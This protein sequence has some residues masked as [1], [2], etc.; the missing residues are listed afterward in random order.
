MTIDAELQ[1][2]Y[3]DG[4]EEKSGGA[5]VTDPGSG[6][7]LVLTS[8]P[9]YDPTLMA[10]GISDEEYQAYVDNPESPFLARYSARYAPASTFKIITAAIG[11]DTDV[12]NLEETRTINGLE[13]QKDESWGGIMW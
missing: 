12:T 2:R 5:V 4:F 9:S 7:L 6:E 13:W 11:L 1:Q 10:R 8:S 3:F